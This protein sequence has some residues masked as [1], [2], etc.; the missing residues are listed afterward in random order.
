VATLDEDPGKR[1]EFHIW[2]SH[3][4]EWLDPR[5]PSYPEWQPGRGN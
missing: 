2:S 5:C 1:P 4:A 3:D